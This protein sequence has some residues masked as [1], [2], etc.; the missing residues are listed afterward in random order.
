[1]W[2]YSEALAWL[3][4]RQAL[5]IKLGLGK[6]ER[7]LTLLGNPHHAFHSVHVAGTNGK[8][9][10]TRMLAEVL[11]RAGFCT[12]TTTSPHLVAFTERVEVDG[13]PIGEN[14]V[15]RHLAVIRPQVEALDAEGRNPTFFEIVTALA[16]CHFRDAG[17]QWAVVETGMGGRLDATN[18]LTPRLT[19]IT[20]VGLDHQAHLGDT[21]VEIAAEKAGILKRGVPCVT[22]CRGD[23]LRVVQLVGRTL[24]IPMSV[25]ASA[26]A[27]T[28][29]DVA[30]YRIVAD[31]DHLVLLRP[32]GESR[33]EV[34]LAG[35]H[36]RENAA[37]VV[38]AVEALRLQGLG[39]PDAALRGGLRHATNPGRLERFT[40]ALDATPTAAARTI[41]VLVDGAHNEDGARA[42]SRHIAATAWSGHHLITGFC[43]DKEWPA[44]LSE[45]TPM[46][47][48]VWAVPVRNPRSLEP[49]RIVEEV[50]PTGRLAVACP[51]LQTALTNAVEAGAERILVAGSLFLA[52]EAVAVLSGRTLEEI[53]GAQ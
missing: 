27:P 40:V 26:S 45:W 50:A 51:D 34:G 23:A 11:R 19:L 1:M 35:A 31:P 12:G 28:Q 4:G 24:G 33:F 25:V 53:H 44:I 39:I 15:A 38:A 9:S 49:Q 37:L 17:V 29:G 46:A 14:D 16:F 32:T 47:E 20:N 6:V 18:V 8:G 21:V 22:A 43:A 41:E 7:L 10:T 30:D 3:Y 13:L 48:R 42:L 2:S 36:Q 52:G 5:G